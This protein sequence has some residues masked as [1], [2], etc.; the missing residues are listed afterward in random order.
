MYTQC[1]ITHREGTVR[2][3]KICI[4]VRSQVAQPARVE[5]TCKL[6][7]HDKSLAI[8]HCFY[9]HTHSHMTRPHNIIA[10]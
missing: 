9:G 3:Q 7:S 4:A 8:G 6:T 1:T 5:S 2:Q 10:T